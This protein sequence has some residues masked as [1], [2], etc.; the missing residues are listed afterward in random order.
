[1]ERFARLYAELD[2]TTST[3]AKVAAMRRYFESA[4]AID[5]AWGLFF[6]QGGRL[7]RL[8]APTRLRDWITELVQLSPVLV[9]ES[10]AHV[11]DL[12]ETVAL[13]VDT[14]FGERRSDLSAVPSPASGRGGSEGPGEGLSPLTSEAKAP[15]SPPS[16]GLSPTRGREDSLTAP[17]LHECVE[18]LQNLANKDES[19]QR[20]TVFSWW[21]R[22]P[23]AQ[24]FLFTKL[25]T[26]SLRV[27][28][29]SGLAARALASHSGLETAVVQHRLMGDWQPSATAYESLLQ[30]EQAETLP[31]QP[32]P[33]CLAHAL[34]EA[35]PEALDDLASYLAE[36]KWD[37][38]RG[39]LI[40]RAGQTWLWSRG[41]DLL[42]GRFPEVET[43]AERLPDGTVL[44]GELLAW[45]DGSVMPFSALQT[46]IGRKN[47]GKKSL[48]DAPVIFLP[49]DLLEWRF[50]DWRQ[51]PL[52]ERR[53]QLETVCTEFGLLVSPRVDARDWNDLKQQRE[54][55]R[56]RGVEGLMLKRLDSPYTP[57]RKT[58][59]WWKWK[60]GALTVDC[61]LIYAQAG[62][63]RRSNLYSDYTLAVWDGG[64]LVP[65]AKAYS[66]LTDEE[67]ASMDRWIRSHTIEKFGP[68][69]SVEPVQVF[70]IAFEN[71]QESR[72]H[73]AGVALRFPRIARWRRDKPASEADTLASLKQLIVSR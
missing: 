65:V 5:A 53:A 71:I 22:L 70:E 43:M 19:T 54:Q 62:H 21:K 66:G 18:L 20:E 9:E 31:S 25:L 13:L 39:Q 24:C 47:P 72:R 41:E 33:F 14:A 6:L 49:Y 23:F 37:G 57:G 60:L 16:A 32:Y 67:L 27:G 68:V 51:R 50:E 44:D 58:G 64:S 11:G 69:R 40:R 1:M 55:A 3:S 73:K 63:G 10:Y 2:A 59:L 45:R 8:I 4:P 36:W 17:A 38:I 26:G 30:A 7:K 56:E 61:V 12:A 15:L 34:D 28:V 52:A 29:S 48:A 46:R 42:N 35:A